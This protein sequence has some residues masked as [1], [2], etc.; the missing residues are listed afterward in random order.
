[1]I[2]PV[3]RVVLAGFMIF[4]GMMHFARPDFFVR[5]V[6]D[7]LPEPLL[8]TW[9][10]GLF[11]LVLGAAVLVAKTR[12]AAGIG[13]MALYVAVLPA[14]INMAL[15]PL[16]TGAADVAPWLL[17]ARLPLQAVLMAVAWWVSRPEIAKTPSP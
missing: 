1:M 13:L 12:G 11:E 15:H 9:A 3:F 7:S 8:I 10:S 14:N 16:Q 5:M 4:A 2:R 6:P 17:W